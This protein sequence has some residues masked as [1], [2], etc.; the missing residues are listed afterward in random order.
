MFSILF[1]IFIKLIFVLFTPLFVFNKYLFFVLLITLLLIFTYLFFVLFI[2]LLLFITYLFFVLLIMLL[3]L[4]TSFTFVLFILLFTILI[5]TIFTII[6][7]FKITVFL[8]ASFM[9]FINGFFNI[10]LGTPLRG[11]LGG[12]A[13]PLRGFTNF[14]SFCSLFLKTNLFFLIK[15]KR[16]NNN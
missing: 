16:H 3:L 10:T 13:A 1:L 11:A 6:M 9:I 4:I 12:F 7:I 14:T 8:F 5:S 15:N 2:V